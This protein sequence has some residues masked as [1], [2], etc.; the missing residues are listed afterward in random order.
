MRIAILELVSEAPIREA[1]LSLLWSFADDPSTSWAVQQAYLHR[2]AL[3]QKHM[4]QYA[5]MRGKNEFVKKSTIKAASRQKNSI[6][7]TYS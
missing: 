5:G 4:K 7:A 3:R 6:A 2:P 1:D